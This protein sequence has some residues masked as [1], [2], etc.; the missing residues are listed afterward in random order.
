[1]VNNIVT[2]K[3]LK[4]IV[5]LFV[6][7][8]LVYFLVNNW[9]LFTSVQELSTM[10]FLN[11]SIVILLTW[12]ANSL[13][14]LLLLKKQHIPIGVLE[15]LAVQTMTILCNYLPMR[16]GTILRFK[17]FKDIHQVEYSRFGG[18]VAVRAY[19]LFLMSAVVVLAAAYFSGAF[20]DLSTHLELLIIFSVVIPAGIFFFADI[21]YTPSDPYVKK[22]F[23]LLFSTRNII[24]STPLI[25]LQIALLLLFQFVFLAIRLHLCFE[26]MGMEV[27]TA[28][29]FI[30]SPLGILLSFLTITPGNFG[31]REWI[32]G[33]ATATLGYDFNAAV[34]ASMIDRAILTGLTFLFGSISYCYVWKK[35]TKQC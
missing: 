27:S 18:L 6:L 35:L 33:L 2:I 31:L 3:T 12:V 11:I 1:M 34:L 16:V 10:H 21:K 14:I 29:L 30:I 32:L 20:E 9:E 25:S 15:N 22:L 24:R 26:A 5:G 4:N 7:I 8:W 23:N 13:Q 28:Q 19:L 17:Y